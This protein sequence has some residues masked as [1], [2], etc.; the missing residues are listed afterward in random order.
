MRVLVVA[1]GHPAL[2]PGGA[3]TA[4]W[5]LFA[6]LQAQLPGAV[7]FLGC[8]HAAR[9]GRA[10]ITQPF[11]P[12]DYVYHVSDMDQDRLA[13]RD[14]LFPGAFAELLVQVAP[15]VVHYHGLGGVGVEA[16]A[17]AARARPGVRQVVT[18]HEYLP[19]CAHHG[20]MMTRPAALPCRRATPTACAQCFPEREPADF[21]LRERYIKLFLGHADRLIAP[22]VFLRDRYVEW[23]IAPERLAVLPNV[24]RPAPP[25]PAPRPADGMLRVG[26]F[27]HL[28]PLQGIGVLIAAARLLEGRSSVVFHL[29]GD[30]AALPADQ[31]VAAD[32]MLAGAGGN[33]RRFGCYA[34]AELDAL[35]AAV[36]VVAV[37][38]VWWE[39]A[40]MVIDA[41]L[42][43]GRPVIGSD[44]GGIAE[45][46]RDGQD[47]FLLPPG[48]AG[49]LARLLERLAAL[50]YKLT[51]LAATLRAPPAPAAAAGQHL[52]LYE[53]LGG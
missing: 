20:Q 12:D 27:G 2:A 5:Q 25:A 40:P 26:F 3:E 9:P 13:N 8:G 15:D 34:A 22:G 45:R 21:V 37:P 53:S 50:P 23:G 31:R 46:V 24:G 18:L 16:L 19:I 32:A 10:R 38:S 14:P 41:A 39:S 6:E 29:H 4:A 49:A 11:G 7:R 30:T 51:D 47:G 48:D 44:I 28:S 35:M 42:A 52:A 33:V 43:R 17:I 1:Q 36:D